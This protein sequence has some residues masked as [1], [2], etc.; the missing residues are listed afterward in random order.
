MN[1]ELTEGLT[2]FGM[3][4]YDVIFHP[5]S[6]NKLIKDF[7]KEPNQIQFTSKLLP[8]QLYL[9]KPQLDYLGDFLSEKLEIKVDTNNIWEN[10]FIGCT[11]SIAPLWVYK[12]F[13]KFMIDNKE[14]I[15]NIIKT[16][17]VGTH[18]MAGFQE[19]LWGFYLMSLGL[20]YTHI[21]S[22]ACDWNSYNHNQYQ[23]FNQL[24][25]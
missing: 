20:P 13:G 8:K 2:H 23:E 10:G 14:E 3:I 7:E 17:K 22:I 19:R 16:R 9:N 21:N 18:K 11:K 1:P 25:K 15:E 6:V 4:H 24:L 5:G 12:K